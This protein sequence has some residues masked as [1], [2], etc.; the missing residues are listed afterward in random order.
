MRGA[1][2]RFKRIL[3]HSSREQQGA[4]RFKRPRR[5]ADALAAAESRGD[6]TAV[7]QPRKPQP[8][9]PHNEYRKGLMLYNKDVGAAIAH[10]RHAIWLDPTFARVHVCDALFYNQVRLS[11]LQTK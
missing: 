1:D 8:G 9:K 6:C 11:A 5:S 2:G 3:T 10:Y 4:G 7:K